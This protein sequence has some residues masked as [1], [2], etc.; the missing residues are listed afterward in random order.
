MKKNT[1]PKNNFDLAYKQIANNYNLIEKLHECNFGTVWRAVRISDSLPVILKMKNT[2]FKAFDNEIKMLSSFNDKNV[3]RLISYEKAKDANILIFEDDNSISLKEWINGKTLS[4]K[5]FLTI[6]LK[7]VKAVETVHNKGIIHKYLSPTNMLINPASSFI[8]LIDFQFAIRLN[9][10]LRQIE[11]RDIF[12]YA[13]NYL[14]PEQTGK[15]TK[16]V[17]YYSD[18]YTLGVTFY[19]LLT[20]KLPFISD[21]ALKIVHALMA[22]VPKTP[23]ELNPDIHPVISNIVMKLLN[24][25]AEARYQSCFGLI[26]D[27]EK[28]LTELKEFPLGEQDYLQK[29]Q[30]SQKLYGRE[31]EIDSFQTVFKRVMN[32]KTETMLIAGYSGIGKSVLVEEIYKSFVGKHGYYI[33]GKFDQL[34]RN[35]PYSAI[36]NAFADLTK[37]LLTESDKELDQWKKKLLTALG[38]NGQLIIDIIPQ[39]ELIIGKQAAV[40]KLGLNESQNRLSHIFQDF[41]KVFCQ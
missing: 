13:T 18:F 17:D 7:I 27:L 34:Q 38:A 26:S 12:E 21:D 28:C 35:I 37:Q 36:G 14:S 33:V 24:K 23:H 2:A 19:E 11:N 40:P 5:E 15:I 20:G 4:V 10:N 25:N 9:E 31:S 1:S 8:K 29:L 39:I 16:P 22:F 30:I 32:G 41:M 3:V 6:S